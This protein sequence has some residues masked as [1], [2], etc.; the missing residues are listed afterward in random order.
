MKRKPLGINIVLVVVFVIVAIVLS[1]GGVKTKGILEI[2]SCG[3]IVGASVRNIIIAL[4][5][6]K[7]TE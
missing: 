7:K 6:Q 1:P 4:K 5:M 3:V 2:F